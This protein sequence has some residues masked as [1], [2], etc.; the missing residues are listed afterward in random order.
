M[1]NRRVAEQIVENHL[2]KIMQ[3]RHLKNRVELAPH[4][5]RPASA[6]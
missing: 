3:K 4:A 1:M 6:G 5:Q 2:R